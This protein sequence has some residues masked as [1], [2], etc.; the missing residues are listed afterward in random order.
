[1]PFALFALACLQIQMNQPDQAMQTFERFLARNDGSASAL[2]VREI[3]SRIRAL[4][5]G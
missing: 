3:M 4:H 2:E 5:G 1:M